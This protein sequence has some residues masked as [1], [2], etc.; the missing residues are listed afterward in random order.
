MFGVMFLWVSASFKISEARPSRSQART[1]G[2]SISIH[3]YKG[4]LKKKSE[5]WHPN[6]QV[7]WGL[8]QIAFL[9]AAVLGGFL[10]FVFA[11]VTSSFRLSSFLPPSLP[12]FLPFYFFFLIH[13]F[14]IGPDPVSTPGLINLGKPFIVPS[15]RFQ[16]QAREIKNCQEGKMDEQ[17]IN[18]GNSN[19]LRHGLPLAWLIIR[20]IR[21]VFFPPSFGLSFFSTKTSESCL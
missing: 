11:S 6:T 13:I 19:L 18:G 7:T 14:Y 15:C 5:L 3:I 12:S 20:G 16:M 1:E 21:N 17:Q 2:R 8:L 4:C 10:S 9:G